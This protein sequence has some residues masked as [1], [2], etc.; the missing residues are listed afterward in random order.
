MNTLRHKNSIPVT[1]FAIA[2]TSG[3]EEHARREATEAKSIHTPSSRKRSICKHSQAA[4]N[5]ASYRRYGLLDTGNLRHLGNRLGLLDAPS[6]ASGTCPHRPRGR[7]R[8]SLPRYP[9][10]QLD[11][12]NSEFYFGPETCSHLAGLSAI[13]TQIHDG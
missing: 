2:G 9:Y 3:G 4:R 11:E 13:S 5:A 1:D 7:H 6:S 12:S 8:R 10:V